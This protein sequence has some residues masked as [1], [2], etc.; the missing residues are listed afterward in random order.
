[1]TTN[2]Y[3]CDISFVVGTPTFT[4]NAFHQS[5]GAYL[6]ERRTCFTSLNDTKKE[7]NK[8]ENK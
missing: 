3:N 7:E 8:G 6:F 2:L 5:T 4:H 1:M